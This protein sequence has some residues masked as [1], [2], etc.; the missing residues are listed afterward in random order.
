MLANRIMEYIGFLCPHKSIFVFKGFNVVSVVVGVI[1]IYNRHRNHSWEVEEHVLLS[2]TD[3]NLS[4]N[5]LLN[6]VIRVI[7]NLTDTE[8]FLVI[9]LF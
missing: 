5:R 7:K 2:N 9:L 3:L 4:C 6:P 1:V 8:P